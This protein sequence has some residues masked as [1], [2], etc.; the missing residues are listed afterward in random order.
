MEPAGIL[1]RVLFG[2]QANCAFAGYFN[3][4]HRRLR[5]RRLFSLVGLRSIGA[6][7]ATYNKAA[8]F[9]RS[10]GFVSLDIERSSRMYLPVATALKAIK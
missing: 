3:R 6:Y 7:D 9:Y 4:P 1:E 10:Y 5:R 2:Y 8:E